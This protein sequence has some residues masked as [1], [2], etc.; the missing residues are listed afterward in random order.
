VAWDHRQCRVRKFPFHYM[1]I[2][3]TDAADMNFDEDL[4]RLRSRGRLIS[5]L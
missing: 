2:C 5:K 1:E 4:T 3:A